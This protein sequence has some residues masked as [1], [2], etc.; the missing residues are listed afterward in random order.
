MEALRFKQETDFIPGKTYSVC[1]RGGRRYNTSGEFD[2]SLYTP[3]HWEN[4][5]ALANIKSQCQYRFMDLTE[6][7]CVDN[8]NSD[9]R[10]YVR[11][12]AVMAD[13]YPGF[14]AREIITILRFI[15]S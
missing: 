10:T 2:L 14:E 4:P 9:A 8:Y 11:L 3:K 13:I 6:N 1:L 5:Q 7:D 15:V 12:A